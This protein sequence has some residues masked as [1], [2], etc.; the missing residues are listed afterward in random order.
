MPNQNLKEM[1][2]LEKIDKHQRIEI[3]KYLADYERE[4]MKISL[5]NISSIRNII[6]TIFAA[7]FGFSAIQI[8][9]LH[10]E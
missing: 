5:E 3:V 10:Q 6:N 2:E 9:A 8:P 7:A 1:V 4:N